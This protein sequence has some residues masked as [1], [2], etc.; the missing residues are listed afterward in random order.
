MILS[1]GKPLSSL[2][3]RLRTYCLSVGG[4]LAVLGTSAHGSSLIV[5]GG[6]EAA[7]ASTVYFSG[8]SLD[9]GSWNVLTGAVY[10][11]SADPY[12]YDGS[13]SLN[14][15]YANLYVPNTVAQTF[16][17]V[18]GQ[19]YEVN[20]WANADTPNSFALTA[21]GVALTGFPG[22]VAQDGFPDPNNNSSLFVDYVASFVANAGM[23]T[24]DFTAT[25]GP[26]IGSPNGSVMID[27][28]NVAATPEP[29][30]VVLVLTGLA[31]VGDLARRRRAA[32]RACKL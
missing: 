21:N 29:Q 13:N 14:L 25:A 22:S 4:C 5:D 17:T 20:F 30:S 19:S 16:S 27:D 26:S 18:A 3:S 10:I 2:R 6:F 9:G 23:T 11:D 24:L 8:Q 7:G 12:V 28:V 1:S 15:T 32:R 31:A